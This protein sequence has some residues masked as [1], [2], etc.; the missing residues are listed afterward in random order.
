VEAGVERMAPDLQGAGECLVVRALVVEG[1]ES[2]A[3]APSAPSPGV[4]GGG[5][6]AFGI[7]TG[8][9]LCGTLTA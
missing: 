7:R 9:P 6:V 8:A 3:E 4:P 5:G 2:C 1:V